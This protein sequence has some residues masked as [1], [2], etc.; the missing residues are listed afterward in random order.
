MA[1][2]T[3]KKAAE[4]LS[5]LKSLQYWQIKPGRRRLLLFYPPRHKRFAEAYRSMIEDWLKIGIIPKDT[6]VELLPKPRQKP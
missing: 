5:E 3:V 6:K 2:L 1:E 4:K